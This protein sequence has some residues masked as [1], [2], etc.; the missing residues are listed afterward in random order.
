MGQNC[1]ASA[2]IG[3]L[4]CCQR[5]N[6]EKLR[7]AFTFLPPPPSYTV[8][9]EGDDG[10]GK[11]VYILDAMVNNAYYQR[12]ASIGN[13]R[14]VRTARQERIPIVWLRRKFVGNSYA[15]GGMNRG[16]ASDSAPLVLL[17]CHGNATDIGMMMGLYFQLS[18]QLGVEIVGVEYSG[19]GA[20]TGAPNAKNTHADVE[21]AYDLLVGAGVAPQR[22]VAYGQSVGSGPVCGLAAKRPLGG[23]V[24]HSPMMSGVKVIDPQPNKCCRPSCVYHCFD[25]YPNDK[26]MKGLGCP[27]FV[28]HG[29]QDDVIPF[30]HGHRLS[31]TIPKQN[32]WPG[33]FP[34]AAGHNDIV[35]TD[36]EEYF[37]EL[38]SFLANVT[39]RAMGTATTV[40]KPTQMEMASMAAGPNDGY[41]GNA[42]P[43][44]SEPVVGPQDGRY[45]QMRAGSHR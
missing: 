27:G 25:F 20:A 31:E 29:Q 23:L 34:R 28:I 42:L 13:V 33:Y 17:H 11:I 30:Y 5:C 10:D 12:A 21:A 7:N 44:M 45:Q 38:R 16:N 22:I 24:L 14:F 36:P 41:A 3:I 9:C 43:P 19:Y 39:E 18:Q 26:M 6:A 35:E 40:G 2:S 8:E 15:A 32:R 1:A 37:K 4:F